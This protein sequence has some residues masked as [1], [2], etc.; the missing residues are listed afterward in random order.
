MTGM[1][2]SAWSNAIAFRAKLDIF[3]AASV[4]LA[5]LLSC[6]GLIGLQYQ[7]NKNATY[8]RHQ[9]I[10]NV[11]SANIGAALV[12]ADQRAAREN[13]ASVREVADVNWVKVFDSQGRE[14]AKFSKP[15]K[16]GFAANDT[17]RV[18]RHPILI[19]GDRVGELRMGVHPRHLGDIIAETAVT[20][21]LLFL[22]C[23]AIALS[24]SRWLGKAAFKPT[25]RL[26][27]AMKRISE[28]GDFSVRV[29]AEPD[30]DFSVI[31]KS[32]NGML[33]EV[34]SRSHQLSDSAL[35][36]RQARDEAQKR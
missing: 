25:D 31:V 32:F 13:L 5:L 9:Q 22:A 29:S 35:Q 1:R 2:L 12:F 19:D 30:P 36:L 26:I 17:D 27:D 10:A 7:N 14:F 16:L 4:A 8:E 18:M 11:I 21:L 15:T 6:V 3:T 28:S 20:A 34:E 23:L 33:D 24:V